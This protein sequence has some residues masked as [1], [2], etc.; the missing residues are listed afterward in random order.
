M[1]KA[2]QLGAA[3]VGK[4][5]ELDNRR[6]SLPE[7]HLATHPRP[8][9]TEPER[10]FAFWRN[11]HGSAMVIE[12]WPNGD[13]P[14]VRISEQSVDGVGALAATKYGVSLHP[15]KLPALMTGL[16]RALAKATERDWLDRSR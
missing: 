3:P 11:R 14:I 4:S 5:D 7:A 12:F 8:G 1:K 9:T 13:K 6:D 15:D 2:A 16:R 10:I